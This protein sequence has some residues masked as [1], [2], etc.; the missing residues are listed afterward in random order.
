MSRNMKGFGALKRKDLKERETRECFNR[1]TL[2]TF[3]TT[4]FFYISLVISIFSSR[5]YEEVELKAI[6]QKMI[7]ITV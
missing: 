3:T 7:K 6:T 4:S 5:F 2:D 1:P